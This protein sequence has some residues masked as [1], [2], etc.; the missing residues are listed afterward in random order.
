MTFNI[1]DSIYLIDKSDDVQ[2]RLV[3]NFRTKDLPLYEQAIKWYNAIG[4]KGLYIRPVAG[5]DSRMSLRFYGGKYDL[6]NFWDIFHDIKKERD[7][8]V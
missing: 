1:R 4:G 8:D 6:S 7:K 2:D 5:D 3:T